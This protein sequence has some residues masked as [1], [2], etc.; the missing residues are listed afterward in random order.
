MH[1]TCTELVYKHARI[2]QRSSDVLYSVY[3]LYNKHDVNVAL[4][5]ICR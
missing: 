4:K 5:L 1:E 3:N 2:P